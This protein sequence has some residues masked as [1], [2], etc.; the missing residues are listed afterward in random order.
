LEIIRKEKEESKDNTE[1]TSQANTQ[2][3]KTARNDGKYEIASQQTYTHSLNAARNDDIIPAKNHP[4]PVVYFIT[5]D[6]SQ[7]TG[8]RSQKT[9]NSS[10][11]RG[12]SSLLKKVNIRKHV[13]G[14]ALSLLESQFAKKPK[15]PV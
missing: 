12:D 5:G 9:G 14:K 10:Q 2:S 13:I 1:I 11:K 8:D 6:R 7:K 15:N 4:H 3:F